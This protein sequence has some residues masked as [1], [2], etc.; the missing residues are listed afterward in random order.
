[1]PCGV[2]CPVICIDMMQDFSAY[3]D[4]YTLQLMLQH[5]WTDSIST[6]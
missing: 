1:M 4:R 3:A 5:F 2:E 6:A